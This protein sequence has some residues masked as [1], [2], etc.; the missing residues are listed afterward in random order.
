MQRYFTSKLNENQ[1]N[2]YKLDSNSH[3]SAGSTKDR[4]NSNSDSM[5]SSKSASGQGDTS[6]S[7]DHAADRAAE[8][9]VI[10]QPLSQAGGAFREGEGR[11][12]QKRGG[13]QDRQDDA[14][15]AERHAGPAECQPWQVAQA[16]A[17][18]RVLHPRH[19]R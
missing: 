6:D 3:S 14:R 13:R 18:A 10:N 19:P 9:L 7:Q 15:E 8:D 4:D 1:N 11:E 17:V 12:D 5:G 2:K 16:G